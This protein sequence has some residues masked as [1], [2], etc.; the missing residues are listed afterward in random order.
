MYCYS[1]EDEIQALRH[2]SEWGTS[3]GQLPSAMALLSAPVL[4]TTLEEI[5][6][7]QTALLSKLVENHNKDNKSPPLPQMET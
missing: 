1:V 3:P 5:L 6:K 7:T 4:P 2:A